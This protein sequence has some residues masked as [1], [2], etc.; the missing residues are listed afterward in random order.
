MI[1]PL[2]QL[3]QHPA[4]WRPGDRRPGDRRPLANI[5]RTGMPTGHAAL[6]RALHA[7]GWPRGAMT[8]LLL[9]RPGSGELG[10]LLPAL[11]ALSRQDR[12]LLWIDP[13]FTPYAPALLQGGVALERLLIVR[14]ADRRQWLWTCTEALRAPGCAAVLCWPGPQPLR[15]ADLRKLQ[16][17]AGEQQSCA[18]LLRDGSAATQ[19]S[20]SALRLQVRAEKTGIS[21]TV[22]KQRG[23]QAGQQVLLPLDKRLQEQVP[24]RDCAF[25]IGAEP[26][27]V[28]RV[29]V[30]LVASVREVLW[31]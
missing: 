11:A 1:T 26:T 5:G 13:P 17:A 20:P 24:L 7:G 21:I 12:W 18:F 3:L 25:V 19:D 9:A 16:V 2:L 23:G 27:E 29:S 14:P 28:P 6:D 15:Y 31:Q 22:L 10:L 8:E 30:P 4:I